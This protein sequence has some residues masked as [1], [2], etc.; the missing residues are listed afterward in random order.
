MK[1]MKRKCW[2]VKTK[3]GYVE[4]KYAMTYAEAIILADFLVYNEHEG[5]Q[6]HRGQPQLEFK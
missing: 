3:E 6:I 5:V 2:Y 1:T 4:G